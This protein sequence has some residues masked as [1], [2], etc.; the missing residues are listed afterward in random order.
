MRRRFGSGDFPGNANAD[1]SRGVR[2]MH[3]LN[4]LLKTPFGR[5]EFARKRGLLSKHASEWNQTHGGNFKGIG[6]D[7]L[8]RSRNWQGPEILS[9]DFS[10]GHSADSRANAGGSAEMG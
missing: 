8:N 5:M 2:G 7:A 3:L 6:H 4:G 9:A 1:P 10:A